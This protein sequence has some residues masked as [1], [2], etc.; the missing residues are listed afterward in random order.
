MNDEPASPS[1]A[2]DARTAGLS[3]MIETV[4]LTVHYGRKRALA[5]VDLQIPRHQITAI[6]GP[7]GCGKSTFLTCLNRLTDLTNGT[8]TGAVYIDGR[9]VFANRCDV[10]ALRRKVGMVFQ[11]PN[12]FPLSVR[13]N[14][15][16]PLEEHGT[17]RGQTEV[18]IE[19]ALR[20]V[21]LWDAVSD[22]L[23]SPAL[24]LS[25]GEQQRLCIARALALHPDVI[26]F[27]EPCSALDP[28]SS[29][30]VEDLI[31]SLRDR[32]TVVIVTHNLSQAR[33]IADH[34]A[35]FWL[36]D[37]SGAVIEAGPAAEV[38]AAPRDPIAAAYLD[39]SRG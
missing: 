24:L 15:A 31:V 30:V 19:C 21:G 10:L 3:A 23:D 11:K 8:V 22:R 2:T 34:V 14:L 12:P 5:G 20:D 26:L 16:L 35:V 27:D 17:P 33:R 39:G 6:V 36:R 38:F 18:V 25:G 9:D 1:A 32:V 28:I 37:E 4:R 7:S 29:A 13:R